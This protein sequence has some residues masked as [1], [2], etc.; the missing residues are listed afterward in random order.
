[1]SN[2]IIDIGNTRIKSALF[3]GDELLHEKVFEELETALG[4]WE[5]LSFDQCIVSSVRW[6]QSELQGFLSFPFTFLSQETSL[7]IQ[8]AYGTPASLGLDRIAGAIGAWAIRREGHVLAI[9]LGTC[10]TFVL[11][12]ENNS[13]LGG[14]IS[15]GLSMR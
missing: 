10:I 9:D 13:Y 8:N 11:I 5:S 12:D 2:L 6:D 14:A 4:Y 15:P 3:K 7:P 1:M